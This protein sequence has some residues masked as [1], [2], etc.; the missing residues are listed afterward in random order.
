MTDSRRSLYHPA[1]TL[2]VE[3][4]PSLIEKFKADQLMNRTRAEARAPH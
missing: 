2:R 1:L 4:L 3:D